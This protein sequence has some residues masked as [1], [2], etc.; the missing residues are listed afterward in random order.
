MTPLRD[1]VDEYIALRRGLGFKLR[2]M[3]TDL[4][5]FAAFLEQHAAPFITT[6]LAVTWAMQPVDHQPSDWAQRL[7][8]VRVFA[9]H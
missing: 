3:A 2:G 1:A 8:F 4:T 5:D 9:R 6:A 7:G